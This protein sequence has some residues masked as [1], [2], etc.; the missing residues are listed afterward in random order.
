MHELVSASSNHQD[1]DVIYLDYH[2]AFDLVPHNEL[3]LKLQKHSKFEST[4]YTC[5]QAH[6][7]T[8]T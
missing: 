3:S 2:K 8:Y 7:H 6:A 1:T 4:L 5:T